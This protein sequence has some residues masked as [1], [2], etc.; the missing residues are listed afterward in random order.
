[1]LPSVRQRILCLLST[2]KADLKRKWEARLR[3]QPV[4]T[5]MAE[6]AI[7]SHLMEET[8]GQLA[9]QL[10]RQAPRRSRRAGGLNAL[11]RCG[12]NPLTAYFV[13]GELCVAE[14]LAEASPPEESWRL[15]L[16][17]QWSLLAW[18]GIGA[19][20]GECVWPCAAPQAEAGGR[21]SS[22]SS[23][24]GYGPGR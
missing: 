10:M 7:L 23:V 2:R 9:S 6:P 17:E 1:M 18:R 3:T 11:C 14:L 22:L 12:L 24:G 8:L 19:L 15:F 13:T 21:A 5:V 20:C 4:R 16:G